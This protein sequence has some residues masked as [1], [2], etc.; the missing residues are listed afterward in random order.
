MRWEGQYFGFTP[1][2]ISSKLKCLVWIKL[3]GK[4][5]MWNSLLQNK[6]HMHSDSRT[7]IYQQLCHSSQLA[8]FS[9]CKLIIL[10]IQ[11]WLLPFSTHMTLISVLLKPSRH[12]NQIFSSGSQRP[13][14]KLQRKWRRIV[15]SAIMAT[16]FQI[17][18][19]LTPCFPHA[20]IVFCH[21]YRHGFY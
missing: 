6:V 10:I 17:N 11:L 15:H 16:H 14:N 2:N 18:A 9:F 4:I 19:N 13:K 20:Q 21:V 8:C 5:H 12:K 3:T 7:D 1:A